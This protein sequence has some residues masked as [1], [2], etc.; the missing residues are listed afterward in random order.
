MIGGWWADCVGWTATAVFVS[1]YF[2]THAAAIR[3]VQMA[4]AAVWLLYGLLLGSYP[5]IVSNVLVMSAA[6]LAGSRAADR[7][8]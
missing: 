3:R 6:A 1:S 4:G 7:L 8:G 5:V 2:F